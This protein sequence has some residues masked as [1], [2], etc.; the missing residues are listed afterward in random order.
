[1]PHQTQRTGQSLSQP[2]PQKES[3]LAFPYSITENGR[4]A[5]T[6][7]TDHVRQM[8]RQL[9]FTSPG[10][11]VNRPTYGC[12]LRR[13]VFNPRR[14][15]LVLAIEA[16]VQ[17]TLQRWLGDIIKVQSLE[18]KIEND[19]VVVDLRYTETRTQQSW[20]TRFLG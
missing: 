11:R 8:I 19:Q 17:S 5:T 15:E 14:G 7:Y 9:L 18:V 20:F 6:D 4:T 13:L 3:E 1:M 16:M 12:D 10:E 2:V